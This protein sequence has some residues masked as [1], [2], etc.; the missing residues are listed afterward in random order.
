MTE[1]VGSGGADKFVRQGC[2]G[3][4]VCQADVRSNA[5]AHNTNLAK[6]LCVTDY[7]KLGYIGTGAAGC[8]TENQRRQGANDPV[9]SFKVTDFASVGY[10]Y[11]DRLGC[12]HGAAATK[13]DN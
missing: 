4:R 5:A 11:G 3:V 10:Q 2:Q 6:M 12:I 1:G 7:G 13:A 8:R 9:R